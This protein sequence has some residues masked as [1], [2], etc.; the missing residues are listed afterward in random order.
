[1]DPVSNLLEY[2]RINMVERILQDFFQSFL[3]E[4]KL[5]VKAKGGPRALVK[6]TRVVSKAAS[7]IMVRRNFVSRTYNFTAD[8]AYIA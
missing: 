3:Y 5:H 7:K 8:M 4:E 6:I 1:M 2:E